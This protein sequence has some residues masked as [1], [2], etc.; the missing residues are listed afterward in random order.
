[1]GGLTY[2]IHQRTP[3]NQPNRGDIWLG[4]VELIGWNGLKSD[5]QVAIF[6]PAGVVLLGKSVHGHMKGSVGPR[7]HRAL[8]L[9]QLT[10]GLEPPHPNVHTI[11]LGC[12]HRHDTIVWV[13]QEANFLGLLVKERRMQNLV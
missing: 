12:R 7:T 4:R 1:M 8:R 3:R 13:R 10:P 2:G 6:I 11:V 5:F 9:G